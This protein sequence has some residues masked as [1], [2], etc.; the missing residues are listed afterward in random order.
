MKYIARLVI[1]LL[2]GASATTTLFAQSLYKSV[3]PDGKVVYSDRPPTQGRIEKTLKFENLPSSVLPASVSSTVEQLRKQKT[4]S[5]TTTPT[6]GV[7]M[8]SATWC[9]Y[10]KKAK[11]YLANKNITYQDV[12]IDTSDGMV[13]YAKAGGGKGVP[14]LIAGS[15]RVQGFSTDA[16][17]E[18]FANRK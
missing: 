13:A 6:G 2:L 12:D 16:Y 9:G 1:L 15:Q 5:A 8:Y 18:I 4:S 10:C 7:V 17:D 3:G 11:A 14:L